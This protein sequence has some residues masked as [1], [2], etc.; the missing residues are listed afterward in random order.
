MSPFQLSRSRYGKT[1]VRVLR[2]VRN[3]RWHEVVEYTIS[4]MLEGQLDVAYTKADNRVVVATDSMKNTVN[5]FAKT[6]PHVLVPELFALHLGLHFV[7]EYEHINMAIVTLK[8]H[9]WTRISIDQKPHPHAFTRDG[10]DT[11]R[12]E[13]MVTQNSSKPL[14][15]CLTSGVQNLMVLKSSGSAFENFIRDKW[16]TL[17]DAPDRILSTAI[18]CQYDIDLHLPSNALAAIVA[19]STLATDFKLLSQSIRQITLETFAS[20]QSAS[21]QATLYKMC[22]LILGTHDMISHVSYSL[23]N[24]HYVPIDLSWHNNIQ[25]TSADKAEVFIPLEAPSGLITA[26]LTRPKSKL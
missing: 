21:V 4:I 20:D 6:S 9:R 8:S 10:D 19:L 2:V 17:P 16:T 26:T 5:V 25:N 12:V 18:D 7:S 15:I 24:K 14:S 11:L 3:G 22:D 13:A 1:N 23:P